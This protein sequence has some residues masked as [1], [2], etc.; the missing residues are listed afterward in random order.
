[1]KLKFVQMYIYEQFIAINT[2]LTRKRA[3]YISNAEINSTSVSLHITP[4]W[5]YNILFLWR[6]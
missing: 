5:T 4:T 3:N 6:Y 2:L 1:M